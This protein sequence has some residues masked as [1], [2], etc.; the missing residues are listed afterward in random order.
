MHQK[1]GTL[2]AEGPFWM[3]HIHRSAYTYIDTYVLSTSVIGIF[4]Y[5]FICLDPF[6]INNINND[7]ATLD[8]LLLLYDESYG[9]NSVSGRNRRSN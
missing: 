7:S 8:Y 9:G 6:I 4:I 3:I 1:P 5:L 2:T